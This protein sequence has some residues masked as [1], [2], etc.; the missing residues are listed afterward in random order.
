MKRTLVVFTL[1]ISNFLLAQGSSVDSI[2]SF[3][4]F[5]ELSK[6]SK[7]KQARERQGVSIHYRNLNLFNEIKTRQIAARFRLKT[8]SLDSV[9]ALIKQ[10]EKIEAWNDAVRKV[11][12]LINN[13]QNWIAHTV[14]DIPFP[15]TQQDLVAH[16]FLEE[17][18]DKFVISSKSLPDYILPKDGFSREGVSFSQWQL[19]PMENGELYVEYSALTLSNSRVPAFIKD[20]IIQNKLLN[21][22]IKFKS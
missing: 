14:Y 13:D 18:N 1:A 20:P 5:I 6:K 21:S 8:R 19:I 10:P 4:E 16:Y 11:E 12:L 3:D 17:R 15:F 22:F 2:N 9:I 7:W